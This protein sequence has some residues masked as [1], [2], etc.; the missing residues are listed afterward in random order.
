MQ[1]FKTKT[2]RIRQN[3]KIELSGKDPISKP[4]LVN[5]HQCA[6]FTAAYAV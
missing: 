2:S 4:D 5:A 6:F 1:N 3:E